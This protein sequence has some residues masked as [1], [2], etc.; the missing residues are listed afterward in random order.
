VRGGK[1]IAGPRAGNGQTG[2]HG[3]GVLF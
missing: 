3:A 1:G 2:M